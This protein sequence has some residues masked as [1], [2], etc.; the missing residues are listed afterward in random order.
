MGVGGAGGVVA[1]P[2]S[3]DP[4][5]SSLN[6]QWLSKWSADMMEDKGA[7]GII[8]RIAHV[9]SLRLRAPGKRSCLGTEKKKKTFDTNMAQT[10]TNRGKTQVM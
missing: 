2:P 6:S 7:K 9:T 1:A 4:P 5:T 8:S 3:P 10:Q